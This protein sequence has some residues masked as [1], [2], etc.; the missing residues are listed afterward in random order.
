MGALLSNKVN[1]ISYSGFQFDLSLGSEFHLTGLNS[2]GFSFEFG[3]SAF[4]KKEFI[5]QTL[6]DNFIVSEVHFYL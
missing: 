5:F 4:K 3:V 6:G 1:Q 2:L